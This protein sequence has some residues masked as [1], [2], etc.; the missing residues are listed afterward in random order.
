MLNAGESN[1]STAANKKAAAAQ[2][3]TAITN[4]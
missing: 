1:V 3:A 2:A 4:G